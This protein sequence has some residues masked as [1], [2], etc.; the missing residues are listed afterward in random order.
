[1]RDFV[2]EI[3]ESKG[4]RGIRKDS[5]IRRDFIKEIRGSKGN[6]GIRRIPELEEIL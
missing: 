5:G 1:M 4:N 3:N 6:R 2:K